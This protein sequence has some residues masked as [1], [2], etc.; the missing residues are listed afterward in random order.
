[1]LWVESILKAAFQLW[2]A[3]GRHNRSTLDDY[4]VVP[5]S[6]SDWDMLDDPFLEGL[7]EVTRM[8]FRVWGFGCRLL[9]SKP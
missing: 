6:D 3:L 9:N 4:S 1:M 8:C 5:A 2:N 7:L